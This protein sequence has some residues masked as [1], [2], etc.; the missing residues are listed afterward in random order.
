MTISVVLAEDNFLVR[1]GV[2]RMLSGVEG[3]ELLASCGDLQ[4]AIGAVD[5]HRPDVVL[6][7]IRMPPR[8]SDEGI[9]IAEH[10][11]RSLPATGVVLLSQYVEIGYV[12]T[13]LQS[14]TRGRG[15]LLKERVARLDDLLSALREVA[16][17]GSAID[18]QVVQALVR[19]RTDSGDRKLAGLSPRELVVLGAIAQGR[20]NAAIADALVLTR[21]A[22][23]KHI[24]SIFT[25]LGLSGDSVSHPRVTAALLYLAEG[26]V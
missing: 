19:V 22:V 13:L 10:C 16:A 12:R 7:D 1:E 14:G 23:E 20:T 6:T 15:Y 26:H 18:P 5:D 24:N 3:I 25:K 2:A 21:H 8:H 4:D 17:G 9:Q 11:R